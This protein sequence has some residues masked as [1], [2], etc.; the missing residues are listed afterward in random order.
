M[1]RSRHPALVA[2]ALLIAI[3]ASLV[4]LARPA[5][6]HPHVFIEA[7][8]EI[9]YDGKGN[10]VA[11]R[12]HWRFDDAF[13]AFAI[14]GLDT[15]GDGEYTR[16]EL[17]DLA[18]VNVNSLKD[19][20]YF[21]FGDDTKVEIDFKPPEPGYW[22][23]LVSV[24]LTDYWAM[25]DED[26]KAIAEDAERDGTQPMQEVKLLE[27][28][29]TLPLKEPVGSDTKVT[30]DVY[31]PTYYI[32]FRFAKDADAVK[33]VN[34]P[35]D[36]ST[37][38]RLPQPL[39]DE[40]AARL[41]AIG[42]DVREPPPELRAITQTLVNQVVITCGDAVAATPAATPP[43]AE[44]AVTRMAA[45]DPGATAPGGQSGTPDPAA[46]S[47]PQS[48]SVADPEAMSAPSAGFFSGIIGTVAR[49]QSEFYQRLIGALRRFKGDSAA[50]WFLFLLSFAYGV[51]HAA[52]PGHGK[53]IITSYMFANEATLKR[54]VAL[55]FAAAFVQATVAVAIVTV[56]ALVLRGTSIA[57]KSTLGV[58]E[59]GSFA[60][61]ALLGAWLVYRKTRAFLRLS[62]APAARSPAPTVG[63]AH[64]AAPVIRRVDSDHG[65]HDHHGH[66]HGHDHDHDDAC[67]GHSH[68]PDPEAISGKLSLREAVAAVFSIG[69]RPCSGALV[70]LVFALSQGLY[71]AG[72]AS[73]Y[74]M[75]IGTALTISTLA[76]I[77]VTSRGIA[78]RIIGAE[79]LRA[80]RIFA[81]VEIAAAVVVVLVGVIF[82][83]AALQAPATL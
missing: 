63:A 82:F 47:A 45:G 58:F 43:S 76:I 46:E 3:A 33:L 19:W 21:T 72:V 65:H 18:D 59:A 44:D 11:I 4:A 70:V 14:Q 42:A 9:V 36:C 20:G 54:G 2:A 78:Q 71:L 48:H 1:I 15:N 73:A 74:I 30:F 83:V 62:P 50:V 25:S 69:M 17:A 60:L 41:A 16:E 5:L 39:D 52:G 49:M 80:R 38:I 34:A 77:A 10:V 53:A 7:K 26:I 22:L 23:D 51:F 32:D 66:S 6:A 35:G 56:V 27:L 12:H 57:M 64:V 81:G 37:E 61:V 40:T 8:A 29:F 67:C 31:D 55:S 24:P 28:H 13:S 75:A 79:T 68:A